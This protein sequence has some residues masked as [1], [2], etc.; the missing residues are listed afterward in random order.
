M[1]NTSL[2]FADL[3]GRNGFAINGIDSGDESG[4]S[5]SGAGDINGDGL[6]DLIIG[7][8]RADTNGY[9]SGESYVVFGKEEGFEASLNLADLDGSDGFVLNGIDE[10]DFSGRSVSGA[11]DINGD[12]L[13]DLIIGTSG[14][15]ASYVVFGQEEGFEA[16]LNLADLDG[17]NGF[18]LNGIEASDSSGYSVSGAGDVNGDG[19]NDA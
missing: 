3:N 15:E 10:R 1:T 6:D 4:F 5:V 14:A 12:G 8:A 9:L 2:N 18:V 11:G 19:I 13:D 16:S 17:S 7:A